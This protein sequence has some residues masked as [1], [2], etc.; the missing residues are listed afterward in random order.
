MATATLDSVSVARNCGLYLRQKGSR[1]WA[2]CPF[3]EEKTASM[4]FFPDGKW[5]C[6]GCGKHGD[7]ADLYA[8]LQGVSLAEA[9]RAVNGG[10]PIQKKREGVTAAELK[11]RVDQW[12]GGLLSVAFVAIHSANA[13]I[14][15]PHSSEEA[16]WNAVEARAKAE[17][18]AN[19]LD[20]AEPADLVRWF[21]N[22]QDKQKGSK[23]GLQH[24][25]AGI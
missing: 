18:F 20:N 16:V 11:R 15:S 9:L 10:A 17:D 21:L 19:A 23:H 5:H 3:H 1:F 14:E 24:R 4:C 12:K 6:F 13:I 8:A 25:N 2:C 7:A 22:W